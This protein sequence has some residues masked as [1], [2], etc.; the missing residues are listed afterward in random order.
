MERARRLVREVLGSDT[1]P[2]PERLDQGATSYCPVCSATYRAGV[3]TCP[4]CDLPL[5]KYERNGGEA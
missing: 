1:L 5:E 4:D 2:P 3:E